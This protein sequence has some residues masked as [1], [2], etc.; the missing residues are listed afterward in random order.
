MSLPQYGIWTN[1]FDYTGYFVLFTSLLP[2]WATRFTARNN[3]GTAKTA[4][5]AQLTIAIIC[6]L[7]YFPSIFLISHAIHTTSYLP[8]Y[9]IA[10]SY[11]ITYYLVAI[12][13]SILQA[14]KPQTTGYGFIIQEVVK[15][16]VGLI[17]ILGFKQIFLGAIL[18]V[19]LGPIVQVLYYTHLLSNYITEKVNW[20]YL[21]EWFK[22]SP[23][24]VYNLVGSQLMAFVFIL[25]FLFGGSAAR[26]DYQAALSFTTVVGY[27]ASLA[28]ALYPKLLANTC[29]DEQVG[30]SFRTVMMLAIP[31][32]SIAMVM[33]Y[34]FLT[35]LKT[36]YGAAWPV[37]V[38]LTVNTLIT[39]IS[40]FYLVALWV[41]KPSTRR[42]KFLCANLHEPKSSWCS[43]FP[44]FRRQSLCR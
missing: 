8:I 14:T 19:T 44:T 2:F 11:I 20:G 41:S 22:G 16:S 31:L 9:F 36:A 37:L 24:I 4:I 5:S 3:A 13:E 23:I 40:S 29:S 38:A 12:F 35:I 28:I 34:S 30:Q 1:I 17:L 15:V 43:V 6:A 33:S 39:L 42:E 21:K 26:A 18:A 25:L 7:A 32:G 10:G 27:S